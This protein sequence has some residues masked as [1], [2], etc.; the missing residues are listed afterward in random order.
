MSDWDRAY[1]FWLAQAQAES[2]HTARAYETAVADLRNFA[3]PHLL[4]N[5][6]GA[7]IAAWVN[8]MVERGLSTATINMRIAAVSSF[9]KYCMTTFTDGQGRPLATFNPA[10]GVKRGKV[11]LYGNSRPL[12]I[13][14]VRALLD[15]VDCSTAS[16]MRDRAVLIMGIYTGRRSEEIRELRWGDILHTADGKPRYCWHGK[17]H[18]SRWD[19]LPMPVYQAIVLY[20]D[21][22]GRRPK[23][24]EFVF[25]CHNGHEAG[26][27]LSS[28]WLNSMVKMYA[29]QAGLPDWVHAHTLRHTAANLRAQ[30]GRPLQE[31][32]MLLGHSSLRVTQIYLEAQMGFTDEGWRDVEKLVGGANDK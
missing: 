1:R 21:A 13:G 29:N 8:R 27:A 18:K 30:I 11:E 12:S 26:Q 23:A 19:D 14:Q 25:I 4:E 16:G 24:G 7:D 20:L 5:L 31:I 6:G 32:S 17:G 9:Y 2:E 22:A 28:E 10:A 15:V 3:A